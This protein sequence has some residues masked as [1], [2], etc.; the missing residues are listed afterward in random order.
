[1]Y[2]RG[3]LHDI[4]QLQ[5]ISLHECRHLFGIGQK[6]PEHLHECR[7]LLDFRLLNQIRVQF[8]GGLLAVAA[9]DA[10]QV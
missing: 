5:P 10:K 8:G 6:Q 7:H 9:N 4:R 2:G 1:V 3:N